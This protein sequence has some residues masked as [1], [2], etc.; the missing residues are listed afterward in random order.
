MIQLLL[1]YILLLICWPL[2][3]LVLILYPIIWA[4]MLS[5]RL[6]GITVDPVFALIKSILNFP[7]RVLGGTK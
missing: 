2:A 7:S 4:I 6:I 5:F 1:W 3:L